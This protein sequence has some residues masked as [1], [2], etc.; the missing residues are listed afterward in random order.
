MTASERDRFI[1]YGGVLYLLL[2]KETLSFTK[3]RKGELSVFVSSVD[4]T[5]AEYL[6]LYSTVDVPHEAI[7]DNVKLF[8]FTDDIFED[9]SLYH[10]PLLMCYLLG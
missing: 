8:G 5:Y 10:R 7:Q 2:W 4:K 1:L 6:P 3:G 9:R